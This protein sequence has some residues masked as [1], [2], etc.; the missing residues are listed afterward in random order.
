[1]DTTTKTSSSN[2]TL[3]VQNVSKT[4]F[5]N[6]VLSEFD[7]DI[8]RGEMVALIGQNGSG[9]STFIKILSG[10]HAPDPGAS[11]HL[12]TK[13]ISNMLGQSAEKTGMAFI[14]QDIP[15]IPSL[16]I[17]ENLRITK[18]QTGFLRRILW[19]KEAAEVTRI[20]QMVG[21][22]VSPF[23]K[24]GQLSVT[25][26]ALVAIA[27]GLSEIQS[28]DELDAQ[29]L[30]LDEPTA[31]LPEDGV[32]RL[33][34]VLKDLAKTGVSILFVSHRLDEVL[35]YCSRAVVLRGGH[36]VGD[37]ETAGKTERNL[38]E[39][40]LG[41]EPEKLYPD[42][43]QKLGDVMFEVDGLTGGEVKN[44]SFDG[45]QGEIV[46]FIGLPG[47]GYDQLPYLLVGAQKPTAG[48]AKLKGKDL[49]YTRMT[50]SKSLANKIV[51]LPADRKGASGAGDI[52]VTHN[53]T[54][55][56]LLNFTAGNILISGKKERT[57]V[58]AEIDRAGVTP[59]RGDA[60]LATLSG[61]NQQKALISKWAMA[62]PDVYVLHEPTQGV[63]IGAK[64]QVFAE[65]DR[66]ADN[67]ALII[68]SSVEY[69]DLVNLCDRV[70]VVRNGEIVQ[71]FKHDEMNTHDLAAAVHQR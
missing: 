42:R 64:R 10:F 18:F 39:I 21:L 22:D 26:R 31:Y 33:F 32:V 11:F 15:L 66:L 60:R 30:V 8:H 29:L 2:V 43:S 14:H 16:T 56:T 70:H 71:T 36:K 65:L 24:I 46:G 37:V 6:T 23:A 28:G 55:P 35:D 61:G 54:L 7:L 44:L 9:K 4:F 58:Q 63:D 27:R 40:M 57:V 17:I 47:E 48:T 67:G 59:P 20:L 1:M 51:M 19:K 53:L 45:R 12:G 25:E 38:V 34:S 49:D 52:S 41:Q 13:D 5:G 68:I 69:E 50:P 62:N 3:S